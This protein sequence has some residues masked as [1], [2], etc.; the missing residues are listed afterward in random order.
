MFIVVTFIVVIFFLVIFFLVILIL[1]IGQR[2]GKV[3]G[4]NGT[5]N[6]F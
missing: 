6:R 5:S 3:S 2:T 1:G 4:T